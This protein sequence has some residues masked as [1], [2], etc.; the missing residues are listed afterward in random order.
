MR[1]NEIIQREEGDEETRSRIRLPPSETGEVHLCDMDQRNSGDITIEVVGSDGRPVD[2]AAISFISSTKCPIANTQI[3]NRKSI[4]TGKLPVGVGGIE[5]SH[6]DYLT[7]KV[8][9]TTKLGEPGNRRI[10]MP[11]FVRVA[12]GK[13]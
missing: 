11:K 2:N 12:A 5:V 1:N 9:F 4:F 10:I 3:E 13:R 8:P 7:T 6:P